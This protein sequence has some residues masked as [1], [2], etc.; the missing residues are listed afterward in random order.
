[1]PTA[2]LQSLARVDNIGRDENRVFEFE[3][4]ESTFCIGV[5]PGQTIRHFLGLEL[6]QD[7][8]T[9]VALLSSDSPILVLVDGVEASVVWDFVDL[10]ERNDKAL[11]L[12]MG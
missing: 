9:C 5:Y 4:Q 1:M 7:R 8:D 11:F 3:R 2:H 10:G 12:G 6:G